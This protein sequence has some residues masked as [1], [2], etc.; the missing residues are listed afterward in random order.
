MDVL[1]GKI[2]ADRFRDKIIFVGATAAALFDMKAIPFVSKHPGVMIHANVVDNLMSARLTSR[3]RPAG[4]TAVT[5]LLVGIAFGAFLP[6]LSPWAKLGAFLGV[7]V[8]IVAGGIVFF[9]TAGRVTPMAAPL[10]AAMACYGGTMFYRLLVEEREKRKIR[11]SFRQ[12]LSPKIIDII[13]RDPSKLQLGR[14]GAR[15]V[16]FFLD[17]AGFTTMSEALK[18][19]QLVEVMNHCLTEFS[20]VILR[21]D[22]LINKYIGDCI[23][24]FWNAP[25][26]QPRHASLA[27]FAALDCIA[28][29][30][31]IN[32]RLQEKGLPS[33]DCRIGINTGNAIVGNMGSIEKFDYTVMGD[34]VNLASRLEGANKSYHTHVMI[35][36]A[37]FEQAREDIEAREHRADTRS[38]I[39]GKKRTAQGVRSSCPQGKPQR[40]TS[41]RARAL[42]SRIVSLPAKIF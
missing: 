5:V 27:S 29:L 21:H 41:G 28:V 26:D 15:G 19:T 3:K 10:A 39:K 24:A 2:P 33:I 9:N 22:G 34:A 18:P 31:S 14:R 40:R 12:Y 7:T 1:Q 25:A 38:G 16:D 6:W 11:G 20:S 4:G 37:T 36:D 17:I 30:P 32:R 35:S 8:A 13:T 23:M 42:P